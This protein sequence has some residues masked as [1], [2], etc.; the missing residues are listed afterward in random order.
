MTENREMVEEAVDMDQ[1]SLTSAAKR[2]KDFENR[3]ILIFPNDWGINWAL[4]HN[5]GFVL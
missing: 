3:N 1:L 2:V 4:D 5:K